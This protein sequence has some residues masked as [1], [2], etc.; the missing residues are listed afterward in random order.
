MTAAWRFA[1]ISHAANNAGVAK[2]ADAKDLKS[3]GG[4]SVPVQV[5]S[6]APLHQET[7]NIAEASVQCFLILQKRSD[8]RGE[9]NREKLL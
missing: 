6:P 3:F 4:N 9:S 8:T 1:I 2:S 7:L 5:R